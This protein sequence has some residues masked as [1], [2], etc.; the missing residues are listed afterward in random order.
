[1]SYALPQERQC[2]L[3]V[4]A[5]NVNIDVDMQRQGICLFDSLLNICTGNIFSEFVGI[6]FNTFYFVICYKKEYNC[7]LCK[8]NIFLTLH[9]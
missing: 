7:I 9:I 3:T 6:L 4:G 8:C 2:Q 1:M 5:H